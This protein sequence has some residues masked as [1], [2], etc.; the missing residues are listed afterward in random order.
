MVKNILTNNVCTTVFQ[1]KEG[2]LWIGTA[3]GLYKQNLHNSFFSVN[4]LSLQ[5]PRMLNQEIRSI[6]VEDNFI[7]AGLQNE[8]G[9][10]IIR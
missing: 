7:Y 1:D 2:R 3:D 6:F 4:D 8:G 9:L 5:S 10:I